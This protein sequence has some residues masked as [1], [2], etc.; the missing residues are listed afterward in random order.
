L[1]NDYDVDG[2][3][4]TAILVDPPNGS[5]SFGSNGA[6]NYN[7]P[8]DWH[9][10]T[11]LTYKVFDGTEYSGIVTVTITVNS[12]NDAPVAPVAV[13]DYVVLDEDTSILIDFMGNDYD[14]DDSFSWDYVAWVPTE[15]NG[16]LEV[17]YDYEVEPGVFRDVLRYTPNPDWHG[18][19]STINYRISDTFGA[20]SSIARI[21][22]TVNSVNDAPVAVD[23]YVV[24]DEDTSLIIDFLGN[25]Y[26][27]D[28]SFTFDYA[29]WSTSGIHG[30][31]EFLPD[32]E[33]EPGIF[34]WVIRYTPDPDWHGTASAISYGIEDSGG[35]T[36]AAQIFITVNPV[37]DAPVGVDDSY[38]IDEDTSL[39]L[40]A[41][42]LLSNDYDVDGD[43]ISL[44]FLT[45]PQH[46][47]FVLGSTGY[48]NYNPFDD[49]YGTDSFTY[50]VYDGMAYSGVVT[51]TITVTSVNDP[52]VAVDDYIDIDEDTSVIID[53]MANDYDVDDD[54]N[55]ASIG[56]TI[57]DLHGTAEL[58][59]DYEIEPGVFRTV[60][61]YTPDPNWHGSTSTINY[62]LRDSSGA[63]SSTAYVHIT[64]HP[65]ND[66]PV[67]VDDSYT[68]DEDT[69]LNLPAPGLLSNDYDVDGDQ[70]SLDFLTYPQH[71]WFVLGSNGY[72]N[73]NPF[74]DW[75]GTDSFTYR[76]FDG[77]AYSGIVTVTITVNP[78]N[79][80]PVA[81]DDFIEIDEDTSVIID[82]MANDYDIDDDFNWASI[83]WTVADLHGTAELLLDYEVEPGVFRTVVLYTP[84][85]NWHGSTS[86]INYRLRDSSG[87]LSST[88]YVHIAV[89]PVNDPPVAVDDYVVLD[90]DTSVIIDFMANDFD[91]D[92]TF[93]LRYVAW[94]TTEIHGTFD[95]YGSSSSIS[96]GIQDSFGAQSSANVYITVN[97]V[98]DPP[99]AVDD[100]VVTDEDTAVIIDFMGNDYDIDDAF[101]WYIVQWVSSDINGE[102]ELVHNYE[103]EPGVF[104]TVLRYTPNPDWYGFSSSIS[105]GIQDSFG[106]KATAKGYIT[107]NSVNDAPVAVDDYAVLDEDSS[108]I[109]DFLGNDY[110]VD[111]TFT[112]QYV[113]WGTLEIH[114]TLELV[115]NYE[116]EP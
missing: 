34:R 45:Y 40:P 43:S 76:V 64:V 41:P 11:T 93:S 50:R 35:L 38:T 12:V 68:I 115:S 69:S 81:V 83:G 100:Y 101:D 2:D 84:D 5:G 46:G 13:D 54:F 22:I 109:I 88:A 78:I 105:Y 27:V 53:F 6:L 24:T 63:L 97:P 10:V 42:G 94:G 14:V 59:L 3:T 106:A 52:P 9:G 21:Y 25:D 86:T 85:P 8:A 39:N 112:L 20:V 62:R 61:S 82:F 7:P 95:W 28:D 90:E 31:L 92:D 74:D 44:D 1:V 60:V 70:I 79:D 48:F 91:V 30:E 80:P 56:W 15:I 104:R 29:S 16:E 4:I 23:D 37:N 55:W 73:Y 77:T 58:L 116:V 51:V 99:V 102:L 18:S 17:V 75:Y 32:Y 108:V 36:S 33:I 107:V 67:G 103:V 96:Y 87:A 111:D 114:G 49:W 26:D 113:A 72:F 47:W 89:N 66:A 65:I 98:N 57:A 71:G 110:D 19:S